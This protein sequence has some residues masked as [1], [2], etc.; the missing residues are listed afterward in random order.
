MTVVDEDTQ[1][2]AVVHAAVQVEVGR[3]YWATL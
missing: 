3:G 1:V 2:F